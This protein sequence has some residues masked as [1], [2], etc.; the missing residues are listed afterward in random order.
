M[1]GDTKQDV[2]DK[3]P[4]SS[5]LLVIRSSTKQLLI[6]PKYSVLVKQERIIVQYVPNVYGMQSRETNLMESGV[7]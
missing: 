3:T 4:T 2:Q 7:D 6:R 1:P 5:T